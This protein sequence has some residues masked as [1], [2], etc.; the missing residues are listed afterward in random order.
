MYAKAKS[1]RAK[2]EELK[3]DEEKDLL[4]DGADKKL[5]SSS[6]GVVPGAL[7]FQT[8]GDPSKE[9]TAKCLRLILQ[10]RLPLSSQNKVCI[11]NLLY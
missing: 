3:E 11:Q 4:T 7:D 8:N 5:K 9:L 1:Q 6:V 2:E 10:G